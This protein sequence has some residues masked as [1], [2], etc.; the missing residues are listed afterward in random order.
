MTNVHILLFRKEEKNE[1]FI[2]CDKMH[3]MRNSLI[4]IS[5]IWNCFLAVS[6]GFA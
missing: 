6:T 5:L 1:G 2:I 3:N 4:L